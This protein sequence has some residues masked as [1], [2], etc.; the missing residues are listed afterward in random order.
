[1]AITEKLYPPVIAASVPAFYEEDG[2]ATITVPFSMNRGVSESDVKGFGLKIK[3]VQSNSYITTLEVTDNAEVEE[4]IQKGEVKFKWN[5]VVSYK[6]INNNDI[7]TIPIKTLNTYYVPFDNGYQLIENNMQIQRSYLQPI[8]AAYVTNNKF[9]LNM[10]DLDFYNCSFN[11]L[12]QLTTLQQKKVTSKLNLLDKINLYNENIDILISKAQDSDAEYEAQQQF[13]NEVDLISEIASLQKIKLLYKRNDDD[14]DESYY[15]NYDITKA[16]YD[17]Y[18]NQYQIL[19]DTYN[20]I[21]DNDLIDLSTEI[22][23]LSDSFDPD[24]DFPTVQ[25]Y[26]KAI[27]ELLKNRTYKRIIANLSIGQ[28]LK[29][30]LAYYSSVIDEKGQNPGYYSTVATTKFTEKPEVQIKESNNN[31]I[32]FKGTYEGIYRSNDLTERPYSYKF[33]LYDNQLNLVETSDWLLYNNNTK[34]AKEKLEDNNQLSMKYTFTSGLTLKDMYWIKYSVRTINNIEI[35]T[36]LTPCIYIENENNENYPALI[37]KNNFDDGFVK[38]SFKNEENF[39]NLDEVTLGTLMDDYEH[40][41][42]YKIIVNG[43]KEDALTEAQYYVLSLFQI[44]YNNSNYADK[45]SSSFPEKIFQWSYNNLIQFKNSIIQDPSFQVKALEDNNK[46]LSL[47]ERFTTSK[48]YNYVKSGNNFNTTQMQKIENNHGFVQQIDGLVTDYY[49]QINND[50]PQYTEMNNF[51]SS[52]FDYAFVD[53]FYTALNTNPTSFKF[54]KEPTQIYYSNNDSSALNGLYVIS[55]SNQAV[56]PLY[57]KWENIYAFYISNFNIFDWKYKDFTVEQGAWYKYAIQKCE[58]DSNNDIIYYQKNI[59]NTIQADFED[60]FLYDGH[61]QLKIR[62]NPQVSSFKTTKL[63]QKID[64]IGGVYPYFFRNG[65]TNYKEFPITG[66]MSYLS[67]E[68]DYFINTNNDLQLIDPSFLKRL[69]S[70]YETNGKN[71]YKDYPFPTASLEGYNVY[72]ERIFKLQVLDWLNDGQ[73]KL[74]RSP[75]EGNY[76]VRLMNISLTPNDNLGRM[77]HNVQCNAY[78]VAPYNHKSLFDLGYYNDINLLETD[79]I[80]IKSISINDL[81]SISFNSG[82]YKINGEDTIYQYLNISFAPTDAI[83]ASS[84]VLGYG[85]GATNLTLSPVGQ[86]IYQEKTNLPN[87]YLLED[88]YNENNY[89]NMVITYMTQVNL[90]NKNRIQDN[91]ELYKVQYSTSV[92]NT[93]VYVYMLKI[94]NSNSSGSGTFTYQL[95]NMQSEATVSVPA[96]I[97]VSLPQGEYINIGN[98]PE[99]FTVEIAYQELQ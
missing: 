57:R 99:G 4:A 21:V 97:T 94:T 12:I 3:T 24:N 86:I 56:D 77:L 98:L 69:G 72:A 8:F 26:I 7:A 20:N 28:Y 78:E 76:I 60:M 68:N 53:L 83:N 17:N 46:L 1:M 64:T 47:A 15:W 89:S 36:N 22:R 61:K 84:V 71:N 74:F 40:D 41:K 80:Q 81:D 93:P 32:M 50:I 37:A 55:R 87:I 70:P 2:T 82:K 65:N 19:L 42:K 34:T 10:N 33:D 5:N 88:Q 73:T 11:Q 29:I 67:D 59:S 38:L 27:E 95:K 48:Y 58:F 85:D 43:E 31:N 54:K 18:I 75:T 30:Q 51:Y 39:Y 49:N 79:T 62:F 6:L 25:R 63:E 96:K 13:L 44:L 90:Q 66:L 35:S 14:E 52:F 45:L 23:N 9:N 16:E 91:E 92:P